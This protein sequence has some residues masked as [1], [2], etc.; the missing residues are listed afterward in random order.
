MNQKTKYNI[1]GIVLLSLLSIINA[2]Q[3]LT[4]YFMYGI[5]QSTKLN[6]ATQPECNVFVGFPG[7]SNIA[8]DVGNSSLN[9][10]DVI[11]YNAEIDSFIT[12]FHP[13]ADK[14]AFLDNFRQINYIRSEFSA[15]ILSFGFRTGNDFYFT[16][17]IAEKMKASVDYPKDLMNLVMNGIDGSGLFDLSGFGGKMR[18]YEE[19]AFGVSKKM[20]EELTIGGKAKFLFGRIDMEMKKQEIL[21]E[22]DP[23]LLSV[24]SKF[25]LRGSFP[26]MDVYKTGEV[27]DSF[28]F[29][30]VESDELINTAL[31][32]SNFGFGVDFGLHYRPIDELTVSAS[33][34]DVGF[35]HWKENVNVFSQDSEFEFEGIEIDLFSD[36]DEE[37]DTSIFDE[38]IDSLSNEMQITSASDP[39]NSM[40]TGK[41]FLGARYHLTEKVN[42]GLLTKAEI[43]RAKIYPQITLSANVKPTNWFSSSLTYSLL[44]GDLYN[45]GLGLNFRAGPLNLYFMSDTYPLVFTRGNPIP[46]YTRSFRFQFGLNLLFGCNKKKKMMD[47]VPLIE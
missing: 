23:Y 6:P 25:D 1:L 42:F 46:V 38:L 12:P 44:N 41:I 19:I 21:L 36:E 3:N 4:S 11:Q 26:F 9:F 33:I 20:D 30:D 13:L 35:I 39:Y 27:V 22:S 18:W 2:Q 37:S 34:L 45:I 43:Y 47:D 16:F 15:D 31:G 17:H 7:I 28:S 14:Q 10:N 29:G 5:P 24:S 8:V 32:R 40:L